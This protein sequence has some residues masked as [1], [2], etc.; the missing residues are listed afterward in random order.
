MI[1]CQ[2]LCH[3]G[4]LSMAIL[5]V[6]VMVCVSVQHQFHQKWRANE[7]NC[8]LT[9]EISMRLMLAVVTK[10][11]EREREIVCDL[12]LQTRVTG[13]VVGSLG[14]QE[15]LAGRCTFSAQA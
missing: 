14:Y 6:V 2:G 3:H 13:A 8:P 10:T 7:F 4:G 12:L 1:V 9:S 15:L 5:V 11:R